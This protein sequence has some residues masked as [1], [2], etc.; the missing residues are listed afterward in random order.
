MGGGLMRTTTITCDI[1]GKTLAALTLDAAERDVHLRMTTSKCEP[2]NSIRI[3]DLCHDCS[4]KLVSVVTIAF[5]DVRAWLDRESLE[6]AL[7]AVEKRVE[8]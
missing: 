1:C 8:P 5:D 4:D 7:D 6:S 2:V 3:D